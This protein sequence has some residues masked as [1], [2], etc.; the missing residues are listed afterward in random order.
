M[1]SRKGLRLCHSSCAWQDAGC[2]GL[3]MQIAMDCTPY[4]LHSLL[5]YICYGLQDAGWVL[6]CLLACNL[7]TPHHDLAP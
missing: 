6:A 4:G 5:D 7:L 2:H 3:W 1:A